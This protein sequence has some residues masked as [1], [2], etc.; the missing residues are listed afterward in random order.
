[1]VEQ[2]TFQSISIVIA[3]TTV[4]IGVVN[5]ILSGRREEKQR[6]EQLILQRV[7][8]YGLEWTKSVFDV[9]YALDWRDIEEFEQ[10][11]GS[12]FEFTSKLLYVMSTYNLAGI[13]LQRGIDPDLIFNMYPPTGVI[14]LWEQY[15]PIIEVTRKGIKDPLYWEP[16]EYL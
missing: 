12:N 4:V 8:G 11:Y 5:S 13:S 9:R 7:Q 1:M 15:E 14:L 3:A 2:I 6:Q 10:K 16:F